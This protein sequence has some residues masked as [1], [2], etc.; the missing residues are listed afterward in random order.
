MEGTSLQT[1]PVIFVIAG[2]S[3]VTWSLWTFLE[4]ALGWLEGKH[5]HFHVAHGPGRSYGMHAGFPGMSFPGICRS[6]LTETVAREA[7]EAGSVDCFALLTDIGN[8]LV[9]GVPVETVLAWVEAVVKP[10]RDVGAKVALTQLTADRVR[11]LPAWKYQL[12]RRVIYPFHPVAQQ[13]VCEGA[14]RLEAGLIQLAERTGSQLLATNPHWYGLDC[15]HLKRSQRRQAAREWIGALIG[16]EQSGVLKKI[17]LK[18]VRGLWRRCVPCEYR[19]LGRS[20]QRRNKVIQICPAAR[21]F[22]Y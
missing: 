14:E 4:H 12:V 11:M 17:H 3:N 20:V 22:C 10:L 5:V 6:S 1:P 19:L 9:Y 16:G 15:V 8:D 18:R 21:L 13:G 7:R 2:A